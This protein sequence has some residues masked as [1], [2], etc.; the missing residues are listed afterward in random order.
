MVFLGLVIL[1]LETYQ[2]DYALR[3]KTIANG[4]SLARV[5]SH[6][7]LSH[8]QSSIAI[9]ALHK[10]SVLGFKK[11]RLTKMRQDAVP[12]NPW[13]LMS[14]KQKVRIIDS[15]PVFSHAFWP[16]GR[17]LQIQFVCVCVCVCVCLFPVPFSFLLIQQFCLKIN[18]MVPYQEGRDLLLSSE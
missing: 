16:Q 9:Y 10:W 5:R 3:K 15:H 6:S 8:K 17:C 4:G 11:M 2:Q 18:Q 13:D 14:E 1:A 12:H 7:L